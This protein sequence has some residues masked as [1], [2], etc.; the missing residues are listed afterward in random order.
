MLNIY[1]K[2]CVYRSSCDSV[3][4]RS[5]RFVFFL[6]IFEFLLQG[7][8]GEKCWSWYI[9]FTGTHTGNRHTW[10]TW[11]SLGQIQQF[12]RFYQQ[13]SKVIGTGSQGL[14]CLWNINRAGFFVCFPY[15]LCYITAL[16]NILLRKRKEKMWLKGRGKWK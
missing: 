6:K 11:E 4:L 12:M 5:Q 13:L 1:K 3:Y 10:G 9:D 16:H 15:E 14:H 2:Y 7:V 8:Q